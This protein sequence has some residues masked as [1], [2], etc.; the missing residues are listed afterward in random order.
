[1]DSRVLRVLA[2][3]KLK[4][5]T[6]I[7]MQGLPAVLMGREVIGIAPS[8]QGKTLVFLLPAILFCI[9]EEKRMPVVRGEGPFALILLPS[10]ELAI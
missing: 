10:H 8:G 4:H 1:V 9:E 7:Q 5:P 3:K 6:P 2:K